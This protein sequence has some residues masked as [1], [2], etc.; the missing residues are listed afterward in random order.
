[1]PRDRVHLALFTDIDPAVNAIEELRHLGIADRQ[2]TI[3]SGVPYL[4]GIL[5]RPQKSTLIPL[6][7]IAGFLFGFIVSLFLNWGTPMLYPIHVGGQPLLPIPTTAVL[8]FEIS[9]LGLLVFTF[10]GVIWESAFPAFGP[11]IY[12]PQVNEGKIALV[13]TCSPEKQAQVYQ[14]LTNLGA[15]SV[16]RTEEKPL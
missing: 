8:T 3:L 10:L 16:D 11:K 7:A 6:F 4:E 12:D 9:M 2:M 14:A 1:M 13:F 15:E 5:G